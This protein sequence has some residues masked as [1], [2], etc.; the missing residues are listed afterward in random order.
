MDDFKRKL[1]KDYTAWDINCPYI[2]RKRK[3]E[4]KLKNLFKRKARRNLKAEL[5][6]EINNENK[7]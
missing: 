5:N 3:T 7:I 4:N 6:K 2:C 1:M